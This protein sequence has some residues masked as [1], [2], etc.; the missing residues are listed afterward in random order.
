MS[1][2][3]TNQ[4]PLVSGNIIAA[5]AGTGKTYQ[6]ASRFLAL[7]AMGVPADAMVALTFT[8]KAAG[9]FRNRIFKTLADGALDVHDE[10]NPDDDPRRN[11]LAQRIMET[12]S[13][14]RLDAR[15]A[16]GKWTLAPSGNPVPLMPSCA[17]QR[18]ADAMVRE[19]V[20]E[21][22][23]HPETCIYPELTCQERLHLPS[24][25]TPAY[26]RSLLGDL[27]KAT[28]RLH[29][30]TLDS[31]FERLVAA[32]CFDAGLSKVSPVTGV[33]YEHARREA[34]NKL[35]QA[36]QQDPENF[37]S[38]YSDVTGGKENAMMEHLEENADR[39]HRLYHRMQ[40]PEQWGNTDTFGLPANARGFEPPQPLSYSYYHGILGPENID[41]IY[42]LLQ[43]DFEKLNKWRAPEVPEELVRM[44]HGLAKKREGGQDIPEQEKEAY[45]NLLAASSDQLDNRA[46]RGLADIL[47]TLI[48]RLEHPFA[49]NA[50]LQKLMVKERPTAEEKQILEHVRAVTRYCED[51]YDEDA[52]AKAADELNA[53][54]QNISKLGEQ[55]R[56]ALEALPCEVANSRWYTEPKILRDAFIK[57]ITASVLPGLVK[58]A[59]RALIKKTLLR[60]DGMYKLMQQYNR[61]YRESIIE[62]G[63]VTFDDITDIAGALLENDGIPTETAAD[64]DARL[65]HW[66][67]DEFQDTNPEQMAVL[68]RMLDDA[69][70]STEEVDIAVDGGT[71]AKTIASQARRASMFVVGDLKQSIYGF[72]GATPE[73]FRRMLPGPDGRPHET[74][75]QFMVFSKLLNSFRSSPVIMGESGFVNRLFQ[76]MRDT[77]M[78]AEDAEDE[79]VAEKLEAWEAD[80][81]HLSNFGEHCSAKEM[82]GFVR[83]SILQKN[84]A[85]SE[86]LPTGEAC[87]REVAR[88][89]R[90]ELAEDKDTCAAL[91]G[92]MSVGIL[93]RSNDEV[94]ELYRSLRKELGPQLPVYMVSDS[95]VALDSPMG[96]WLLLFFKW[97]AHPADAFCRAMLLESTVGASLLKEVA[98]FTPPIPDDGEGEQE[99]PDPREHGRKVQLCREQAVAAR[100]ANLLAASGYHAVLSR[101]FEEWPRECASMLDAATV[102]T[103]LQAAVDFDSTG[104]DLDEWIRFICQRS[105]LSVP[106]EKSIQIMTMHKSKGLEFDA[107]ILPL[108]AEKN[109]DDTGKM[110]HF[111][112]DDNILMSPGGD[113]ARQ[114]MPEIAR[115]VEKWRSDARIEEYNLLY[116][117]VTRAKRANYI[118]LHADSQPYAA[119][120][121]KGGH[122]YKEDQPKGKASDYILRAMDIRGEFVEI[123][124]KWKPTFGNDS[125]VVVLYECDGNTEFKWTPEEKESNAAA[126]KWYAPLVKKKE[127]DLADER[128][129]QSSE[130]PQCVELPVRQMRRKKITPSRLASAEDRDETE[131]TDRNASNPYA[132]IHGEAAAGYGT[133]VHACFERL[134]WLDADAAGLFPGDGSDAAEAVRT[135]LRNPDIAAIFRRPNARTETFNEQDIDYIDTMDGQEVWV[136]G[137][138]DRLVVEYAEDG[139]TAHR[140]HIY[141]YKTNTMQG[142]DADAHDATLR[143]EYAAQMAAY[144]KAVA[145]ALNLDI[146]KVETTLVAVPRQN[147]D[148]AHLVA[149]QAEKRE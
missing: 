141:D 20:E 90:E 46:D 13:G 69:L 43:F 60:T 54:L 76:G 65:H 2:T 91:K 83:I 92:D 32:N 93:V 95:F 37:F 75:G 128:E 133:A 36:A 25:L 23:T 100:W 21:H 130:A 122:R 119:D 63:R 28:S 121:T 16:H 106:P 74:W 33:D 42:A 123:N 4:L 104:G 12:L 51:N 103:W 127:Q 118:L 10:H 132:V 35:L 14:L 40:K 129:S 115:F 126:D 62:S 11:P 15:D 5:S 80:V 34:A 29:L 144:R 39:Y 87:C 110:L 41:L 101:L 78:K 140:A 149:V 86:S 125:S 105:Y 136:S 58:E 84:D 107:A 89:I 48:E 31:F 59:R 137:V 9:E 88:L 66:M 70:Q 113:G 67:L 85:L 22:N 27:V 94:L 26:F 143:G 135:A 142:D 147:A 61:A 108:V 30:S 53:F 50:E 145:K 17:G 56:K 24:N 139:I 131:Q 18:G 134:E 6:L 49:L 68:T 117:A 81:D 109:V 71:G 55:R 38:L 72:R 97:L 138:I 44:A 64:L 148:K 99:K 7:L 102:H 82:P 8:K 3:S 47:K 73:L 57:V 116:V 111:I 79:E 45:R 96:E 120:E 112:E 114:G 19:L 98:A 77:I 52:L 1:T 146:G 124:K